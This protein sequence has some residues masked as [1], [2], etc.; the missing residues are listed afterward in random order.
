MIIERTHYYAKPGLA[1]HVL[2]TRRRASLVRI[3][4]GLPA[5]EIRTK[6]GGNGPDVSWQCAF[7]GES[8]HAA[9]LAA[10]ASSA[11]FEAVRAEMR[12][13]AE[14]FARCIERDA[15]MGGIH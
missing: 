12:A 5:G 9:D 4:I 11:E 14:R 13:A 10:R 3:A 15:G 2:A 7:A 1:E 8:E 6:A